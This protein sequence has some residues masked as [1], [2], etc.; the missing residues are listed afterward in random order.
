MAYFERMVSRRYLFSRERKALV[1]AITFISVLGVTVGV[2]ALIIVIG[3]IDGIDRDILGKFVEIYPHLRVASADGDGL[4]DPGPVLAGLEGQEGILR[5][6]PIIQ[7]QVLLETSGDTASPKVPGQIIGTDELGSDR[8]YQIPNA[9]D[10]TNIR[11]ERR[12]ILLGAPLAYQLGAQPGD[13][14]IATT[15]KLQRTPNGWMSRRRNLRVIGFFNTG[16]WEFDT[17]T[18]FVSSETAREIFGSGAGADF[19]QVKLADPFAVRSVK[20]G[21]EKRIGGDF[22]IRTWEEE[23]AEFFQALKLEKLGL[24]VILL[25]VVIVASFNIIGTLILVVIEKTPEIGILKAV[26]SSDRMIRRVF[27]NSGLT[28]G[29]IGTFT[30]LVLGVGGCLLVKY[31]IRFDLPDSVYAMNR[32]PVVIKPATVSFIVLSALAISLIAAIFPAIQAARLDAVK[33]IRQE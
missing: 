2:A 27:I 16:L 3:V 33:A 32:L 24:I 17:Q 18:A 14:I 12:E 25:L 22:Q 26:G 5:A 29:V 19:V 6:E 1:S 11:L 8:I 13:L 4:T 30:G 31:V 9:N 21:L 7:Q 28:I 10:G 20:K 15:G 23:N